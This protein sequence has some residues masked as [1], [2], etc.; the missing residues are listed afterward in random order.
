MATTADHDP[1]MLDE[2]RMSI[3]EHLSE[4]R[5][6]L[7]ISVIAVAVGFVVMSIFYQQLLDV[8]VEPYC[9]LDFEN[10]PDDCN[11]VARSPTE[12][13]SVRMTVSLYSGLG[14]AMPVVLWQIW[15][16]IVP[17]LYPQERRY[18]VTFVFTAFSL[19][20][21]GVALSYWSIPKALLFLADFGGSSIALEY[22]PQAY[23]NFVTKM[24]LGAGIGFQFPIVLIFLQMI[25]LITNQTLRAGRRY[26]IVGIVVLVAILTPSGDPITLGVLSVPMYLFYEAAIIFGRIRDRRER[27]SAK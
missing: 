9:T 11:L 26:A 14:L 25:G 19:F 23:I 5:R 3:V 18:G 13:F 24:L 12:G 17:G 6:R 20:A 15:K 27:L 10:K 1:A 7:I 22:Q 8:L 21:L 16:F 4:L 2:G